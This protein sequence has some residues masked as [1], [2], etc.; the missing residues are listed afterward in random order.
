MRIIELVSQQNKLDFSLE[1]NFGSNAVHILTGSNGSGKS[2]TLST[3]A[4]F[5]GNVRRGVNPEDIAWQHQGMYYSNHQQYDPE[6]LPARTITQTFSPFT[7]FAPSTPPTSSLLEIYSLGRD[8]GSSYICT[9]LHRSTRLVGKGLSKKILEQS[10]FRMSESVDYAEAVS[11]VLQEIDMGHEFK[12]IYGCTPQLV[13]ILDSRDRHQSVKDLLRDVRNRAPI[14]G[15]RNSKLAAESYRNDSGELIELISAAVDQLERLKIQPRTFELSFNFLQKRV[16]DFS[17]FQ[18]LS[19]LRRLGLLTLKSCFITNGYREL[20]DVSNTSSGQQQMLCSTL[21]LVTALSD[22]TLVLI[23][24]PELSLHPRWQQSYLDF[25]LAAVHP[26]QDCHIIIAT[27]SPLVVQSG[28]NQGVGIIKM[29]GL[30]T[31]ASGDNR[32]SS[33]ESALIDVFETPVEDSMQLASLVFDA[34]AKGESGDSSERKKCVQQLLDLRRIYS[35][36]NGGHNS[37]QKIISDAI[38]ILEMS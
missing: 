25:L 12:L 3:L 31:N 22:N 13:K 20:I 17:G 19:L 24:E 11:K 18:S 37:D 2:E 32:D 27:H 15:T 29:G 14:G 23:D 26:F 16:D 33:V 21:S 9:G 4:G 6:A 35:T 10:L 36:D 8:P 30:S 1:G 38:R 5:F 28:I 34:V 7:R